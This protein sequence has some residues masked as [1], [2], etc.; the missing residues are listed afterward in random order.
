M[1]KF[2]FFSTLK[3]NLKC[4]FCKITN[5]PVRYTPQRKIIQYYNGT[6]YVTMCKKDR[7]KREK[8]ILKKRLP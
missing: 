5:C 3:S 1:K 8:R 4:S 7:E 2:T 6:T